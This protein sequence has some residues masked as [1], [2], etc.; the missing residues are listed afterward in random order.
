MKTILLE[1]CRTCGALL[2]WAIA[3]PLAGLFL[4]VLVLGQKVAT[5]PRWNSVS[6]VASRPI[7][8]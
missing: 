2:F 6:V 1:L 8:A 4:P 3:L 7:A 5:K